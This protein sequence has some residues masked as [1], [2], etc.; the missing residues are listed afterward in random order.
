MKPQLILVALLFAQTPIIASTPQS[1]EW[2]PQVTAGNADIAW[3]K[4]EAGERTLKITATDPEPTTV[5]LGVV[6]APDVGS[7]FYAV[8]GSVRYT[9]VDGTAYLEMWNHFNG[10]DG[11]PP[12][13]YFS[14]TLGKSGL[15]QKLSG[16]SDWRAFRL[17]FD[18][19]KDD[20]R[21]ARLV[22]NLVLPGRGS[23]ELTPASLS[24]YASAAALFSHA[25]GWWPAR[26]AGWIGAGMGM[27]FGCWGSLTGILSQKGIARG[28]VMVSVHINLVIGIV[29]LIVGA[30]AITLRQ[31]YHVWYPFMLIGI[32]LTLVMSTT[33]RQLAH[34]LT[35]AEEEKMAKL[36]AIGQ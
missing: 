4:S 6:E 5:Q 27:L 32:I 15:M 13:A 22:I 24:D 12:V 8:D 25:N 9:Q 16:D 1:I 3:G 17:P 23:V 29:S 26:W 21:P 20:Q 35:K 7:S 30:V 34:Q 11:T 36:D 14:R 2:L 33:R 28:F 18:A 19:S 10:R 31:P